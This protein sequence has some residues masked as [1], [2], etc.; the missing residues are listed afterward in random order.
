MI[1][2]GCMVGCRWLM[3][4]WLVW[5]W[6]GCLVSLPTVTLGCAIMV[7][8]SDVLVENCSI[9]AM[10]GVNLSVRMTEVVNLAVSLLIRIEGIIVPA[11]AV[12]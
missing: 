4:T 12:E 7:T 11:S 2:G 9:G 1:G 8:G 5:G 3:I 6:W 10:V